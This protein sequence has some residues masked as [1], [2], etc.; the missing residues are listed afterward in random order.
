MKILFALLFTAILVGCNTKVDVKTDNASS[1][2]QVISE[3]DCSVAL[4][5]IN[6]YI[7]YSNPESAASADTN[8]IAH[9]NL[10]TEH[11]KAMYKDLLDTAQ[12]EEMGL[13]ADPILD[14]QDFPEKG[15]ELMNCDNETGYVTLKGKD[16]DD[17]ILVLK[18]VQQDNK[19]LVDGS[20]VINIPEAKRA[21]R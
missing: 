7:D 12:K 3:P 19:W 18:L 11:F 15:F 1:A 2:Q 5:F 6:D 9:N 14:A 17:F 4:K 16:W 13:E 20:G 21:K 8:W 10:L